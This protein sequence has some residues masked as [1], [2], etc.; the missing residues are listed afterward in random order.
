MKKTTVLAKKLLVAVLAITICV[1]SLVAVMVSV[2]AADS[3][4]TVYDFESAAT[5]PTVTVSSGTNVKYAIVDYNESKQLEVKDNGWD[6]GKNRVGEYVSIA[7]TEIGVT[8]ITF[9]VDLKTGWGG[10][11]TPHY[12]VLIDGVPYW[13]SEW[14]RGQLNAD[15]TVTI[16]GTTYVKF[17]GGIDAASN[18]VKLTITEDNIDTIDAILIKPYNNY[19]YY[20]P[21]IDNITVVS[22]AA[23]G[24]EP[25]TQAPTTEESTQAPT[26]EAPTQAPTTEAPTQ[27]PTTEAP[28][29]AP[30]TAAPSGGTDGGEYP[31]MNGYVV[32]D[33][34]KTWD[35]F[36]GSATDTAILVGSS[37]AGT[38]WNA[39][40]FG[41]LQTGWK[42]NNVIFTGTAGC[43]NGDGIRIWYKSTSSTGCALKA[44][45][46]DGGN[47]TYSFTLAANAEGGWVTVLY[48]D[49]TKGSSAGD[50]STMTRFQMKPNPGV[51]VYL[52][53][54]HTIE[55]A[56]T[57]PTQAPTTEAPTTE[58]PTTEAPTTEAPTQAP[59]TEA[60]TTEAPTTEAPTTTAPATNA[61]TTTAPVVGGATF[62]WESGNYWKGGACQPTVTPDANG[63]K[64]EWSGNFSNWKDAQVAAYT[65]TNKL[66]GVT[67]IEFEANIGSAHNF[68]KGLNIKLKHSNGKI[69]TA[70][71]P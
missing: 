47:K 43:F 58:A 42:D 20:I 48:A 53:E 6:G 45:Q 10:D 28:T 57:T 30:T 14:T 40:S 60:P 70:K 16:L 8:G 12:G 71:G 52:D 34:L 23:A 38:A 41:N 65:F 46:Y 63:A 32:K 62:D 15:K 35:D 61:P 33:V 27:A 11:P 9:D 18:K 4:T 37:A 69:Y 5:T 25:T 36:A 51:E 31:A 49:M 17:D 7:I 44:G 68:N 54:L 1:T 56:S 64:I 22:T 66:V 13:D 2:A 3:V 29:Q 21:Y 67:G 59:T 50:I 26:T 55:A 19:Q 24:G 39:N